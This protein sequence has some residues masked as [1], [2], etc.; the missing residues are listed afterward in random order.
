MDELRIPKFMSDLKDKKANKGAKTFFTIKC[1]SDPPPEVKWYLNDAEVVDGDNIKLSFKE[2]EHQYR[3]DILDVQSNTAGEIKVVAKNE[4]GEDTKVGSLEVQF[5]PEIDDIGEWK[6]GP[7]D[8][9]KIIAKGKA[10]PFADATW[11][12]VLEPASEEGGEAKVEKIDFEDKAFKR[13]SASVEENGLEAT[14]TL[15][16]K[17]A[18][19]DDAGL[20]ELSL[21][22]RVGHM[23]KQA[24]LAIVTEEPSF[25][26]PLADITTTL[27]S[28]STFE[29]VVAGVLGPPPPPWRWYIRISTERVATTRAAVTAM[30]M[31]VSV[32]KGAN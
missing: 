32:S 22:N 31:V 10:F 13:F 21:A 29:A 11:Y 26:K 9:A 23:E 2:E 15:S 20:Y 19:L 27:G 1:R 24:S 6:A 8:E 12:K 30:L 5:S 17:D 3:L 28:T 4:N 16:I 7:G 14:Y 18:A 25:P